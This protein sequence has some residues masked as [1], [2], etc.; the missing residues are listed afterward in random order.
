MQ[1]LK[2]FLALG[3]AVGVSA[4]TAAAPVYAPPTGQT[5]TVFVP[6]YRG[7]F[8]VKDDPERAR[9]YLNIGDVMSSGSQNLALP[10]E[11]QRFKPTFPALAPDGPLT[12]MTILPAIISMDIYL[13]WLKFGRDELPGFIPFGYDWRKDVNA[14]G[15]ALCDFLAKLPAANIQIV[16]HSKGGLVTWSCLTQNEAVAQRVKRVVF[17]GTPFKGGPGIF[18]DLLLGSATGLNHS[19]LSREA[20]FSFFSAYQLLSAQSDFFVDASGAPVA[21]DA[22]SAKEWVSRKWGIFE[23]P[24]TAADLAQL[25]KLLEGHAA[26]YARVASPLLSRPALMAVIGTG[27]P[28]VSG[29]R[30][31][32]TGFDFEHPAN[33]DGDGAVLLSSAA[34]PLPFTRVDTPAEHVVLL[35]DPD[36]QRA[37]AA[38][39]KSPA[40]N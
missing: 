13:T 26:L 17:A 10:Y 39:L 8:L 40:Q 19:L 36:V 14:S 22:L 3:W 34:P 25:Q 9:V 28:T 16:A 20:L 2:L 12:K 38:F 18:D 27:H 21:L 5:V 24:T 23:E 33:A 15:Q 6:G 11:G 29:V 37:I 7:S 35:N 30:V 4:C 31:T 1:T 32:S